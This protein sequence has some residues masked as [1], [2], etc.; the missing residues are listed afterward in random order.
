MKTLLTFLFIFS[1]T[2]VYALDKK[3]LQQSREAIVQVKKKSPVV[4]SALGSAHAYA[5]LPHVG[6]GGFI[7][8]GTHG[9]G[10]VFKGGSPIGS[11]AMTQTTVGLTIGG[12][13]YIEVILFENS[14]SL[15]NFK[16]GNAK[17]TAGSSL[18]N[19]IKGKPKKI[20]YKE[21]L[22]IVILPIGGVMLDTS[23][24]GQGFKYTP[25]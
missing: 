1:I 6:S 20:K 5:V 12:K 7:L 22:A 17:F 11:T 14:Q 23:I 18:Y 24:G 3:L 10:I 2:S 21:G 8:K 19:L 15:K 9:K 4:K 25:K 13:K 16:E